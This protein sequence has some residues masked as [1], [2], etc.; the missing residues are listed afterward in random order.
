MLC[1]IA[2]GHRYVSAFFELFL[3]RGGVP[4]IGE[5]IR[6]SQKFKAHDDSDRKDLNRQFETHACPVEEVRRTG[7]QIISR[8]GLSFFSS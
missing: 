5:C 4:I 3:S 2:I 7:T 1:P 6:C 8:A